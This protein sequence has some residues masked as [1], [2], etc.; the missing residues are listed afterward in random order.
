MSAFVNPFDHVAP[1]EPCEI[2]VRGQMRKFWPLD[3]DAIGQ[4]AVRFP[5][6]RGILIGD[7]DGTPV[8]KEDELETQV[9]M[10]AVAFAPQISE[11]PEYEAM[12]ESIRTGFKP[13]EREL[14]VAA[15][16]KASIPDTILEDVEGNVQA[17]LKTRGALSKALKISEDQPNE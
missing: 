12:L 13:L 4:L 3:I 9:A 16:M 8:S 11:G 5:K 10:I 17:P 1:A 6:A 2:N 7:D 14:I 15:I